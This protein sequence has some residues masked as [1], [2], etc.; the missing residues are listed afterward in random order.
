M[1]LL[2]PQIPNKRARARG[3]DHPHAIRILARAWIR[4][5]WRAWVSKTTYD[6]KLHIG[7]AKLNPPLAA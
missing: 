1:P 5:L 6:Q 2:G 4:I 7:A 3:C